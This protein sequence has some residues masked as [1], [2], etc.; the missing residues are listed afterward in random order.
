MTK[1]L[2]VHPEYEF[3]K[4]EL[5]KMISN[6]HNEG[7]LVVAGS[8]NIIKSNV[9]SNVKCSIKFFKTPGFFKSIIYGYFRQSKAK[10]SFDY[11]NHLL[12]G[13]VLTPF[14]IAYYEEHSR[15][16]ILK[17]SFYICKH[18]DYDFTFREL[19][20]NPLFPNRELI[21]RKF[22]AF[23]FNM[24]EYGVNFLDHS[25]GNTLIVTNDNDY[26]FYLIDL[27]RMSFQNMS[28]AKRMDNFKK[29]WLSKA[30]VKIIGDEYAKLSNHDS[31]SLIKIL[32]DSTLAF[33]KKITKKKYLKRKLKRK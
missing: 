3:M 6:F 32:M 1:T 23:T 29:L 20:H 14:P 28:I 24:H 26:E 30:M 4:P 7:K 16:G 5:M 21:L 8:R 13:N 17:D 12:K 19:I 27:N 10:R 11:A 15:L 2:H 31:N 18:V 9:I 22:A 33:K 25:P